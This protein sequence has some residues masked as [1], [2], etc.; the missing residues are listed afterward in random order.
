M[1]FGVT[2][3]VFLMTHLLPGDPALTILGQSRDARGG[4]HPATG[5]WGLDRP[6]SEQYWLFLDRLLARQPRHPLNYQ[7][8][9]GGLLIVGRL[10]GHALADG[11]TRR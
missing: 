5:S 10:A 11:A 6:L 3:L 4:G 8:P 9:V 1:A 7:Q 2:I